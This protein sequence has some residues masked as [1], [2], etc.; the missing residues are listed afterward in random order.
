MH[1]YKENKTAQTSW[2]IKGTTRWIKRKH[3]SC[4]QTKKTAE[5]EIQH[6]TSWITKRH[7]S[8]Q[9][10]TRWINR[11]YCCHLKTKKKVEEEIL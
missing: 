5:E 9:A 7:I 3:C 2:I 4:L 6:K 1:G 11:K 10:T 8:S